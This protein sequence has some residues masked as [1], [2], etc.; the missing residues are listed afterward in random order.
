MWRRGV[1]ALK[2]GMLIGRGRCGWGRRVENGMQDHRRASC[3]YL[4]SQDLETEWY[5]FL[6]ML[7]T[8][9]LTWKIMLNVVTITKTLSRSPTYEYST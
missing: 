6:G 8:E 5:F 1:H 3:T 2:S 7:T 9:L 4:G